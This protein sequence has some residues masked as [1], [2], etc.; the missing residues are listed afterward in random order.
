MSTTP[1]Q[2]TTSH[3]RPALRRLLAA[4]DR[5]AAAQREVEAA[6]AVLDRAAQCQ[7]RLV[8]DGDGGEA[9]HAE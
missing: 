6:R 9:R 7:I 3:V 8:S 5:A 2:R 4:L 1:A